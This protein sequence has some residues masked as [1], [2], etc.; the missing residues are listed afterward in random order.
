MT[1]SPLISVVVPNYNHARYLDQRLQSILN[2]TYRNIEVIILDDCSIDNSLE[3]ISKYT[4]D[5]RIVSVIV[6]DCLEMLKISRE[7]NN[8]RR[9][10]IIVMIKK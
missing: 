3:V 5:S 10:A 7:G 2:Q 6:R 4:Y 1:A 9:S 8:L